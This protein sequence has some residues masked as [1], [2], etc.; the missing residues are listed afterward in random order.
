VFEQHGSSR[1]EDLNAG[2]DQRIPNRIVSR[3]ATAT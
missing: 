2:F 3:A 1:F